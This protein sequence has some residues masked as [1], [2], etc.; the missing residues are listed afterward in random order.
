MS[1]VDLCQVGTWRWR[2]LFSSILRRHLDPIYIGFLWLD[3]KSK[4]LKLVDQSG[5][6]LDRRLLKVRE[7]IHPGLTFELGLYRIKVQGRISLLDGVLIERGK[8]VEYPKP[9]QSV[10]LLDH[11]PIDPSSMAVHASITLDLDFSRG[12]AFAKEI[13][14]LFGSDVHYSGEGVPFIMIVDFARATFRM[15]EDMASLA[16]E[17]VLGGFCGMLKVQHVKDRTFLFEV[18]SKSVGFHILQLKFY[19][20]FHFKCSFHLWGNG[21]PNW[22]REFKMWQQEEDRGWTVVS[23]RK[24]KSKKGSEERRVGKECRL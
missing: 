8:P 14:N 22:R 1:P 19:E 5:V 9:S 13:R 20:C 2:A 15:E 21:G 11:T 16:L 10:R 12:I 23:Y 24:S 3:P 6:V 18:A 17:A 4:M 7:C